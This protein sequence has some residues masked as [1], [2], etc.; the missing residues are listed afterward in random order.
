MQI[1]PTTYWNNKNNSFCFFHNL[2]F[3][4]VIFIPILFEPL[5]HFCIFDTLICKLIWYS[6]IITDL[7]NF[8]ESSGNGNGNIIYHTIH[9]SFKHINIMI[10]NVNKLHNLGSIQSFLSLGQKVLEIIIIP[11]DILQLQRKKPFLGWWFKRLWYLQYKIKI[12]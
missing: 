11:C 8:F 5:S 4:D 9:E 10:T 12:K 3:M 7:N 2:L 6:N 1:W